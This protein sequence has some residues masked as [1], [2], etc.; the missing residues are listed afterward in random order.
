MSRH[1]LRLLLCS[2]LLLLSIGPGGVGPAEQASP[3]TRDALGVVP[4]GKADGSSY[5]PCE[6]DAVVAWLNEGPSAESLREAGVHTRAARNLAAH[7]DGADGA[8]GTADDDRFDDIEEVDGVFFVGPGS[9]RRSPTR[10]GRSR[11]RA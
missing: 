7:R 11:R 4:G 5:D 6:L 8:F 10:G 2:S 1:A 3:D 9:P